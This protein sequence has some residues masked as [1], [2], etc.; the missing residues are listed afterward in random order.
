M[1]AEA[2]PE[3]G[4]FTPW[5]TH[6]TVR[7]AS[8]VELWSTETAG[9]HVYTGLMASLLVRQGFPLSPSYR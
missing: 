6:P 2:N 9:T 7:V 8:P 1:E 4:H 5:P 3:T